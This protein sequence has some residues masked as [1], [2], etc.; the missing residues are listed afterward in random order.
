MDLTRV[1]IPDFVLTLP[2]C[3]M[4]RAAVLAAGARFLDSAAAGVRNLMLR[5]DGVDLN[6]RI[7]RG[8]RD[9]YRP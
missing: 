1:R 4:P 7:L 2:A 3:R 9:A 6:T 8:L 5:A